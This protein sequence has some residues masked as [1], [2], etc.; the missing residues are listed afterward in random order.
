[1][2]T[3]EI[4]L[5]SGGVYGWLLSTFLAWVMDA[6]ARI[7]PDLSRSMNSKEEPVVTL[8]CQGGDDGVEL[9]LISDPTY[10]TDYESYIRNYLATP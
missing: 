8:D 7:L 6:A 3:G 2:L 5:R 10:C 9:E 1:M 4:S